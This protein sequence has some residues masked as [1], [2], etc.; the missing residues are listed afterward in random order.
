MLRFQSPQL[1]PA[2]RIERHLRRSREERW[3]SNDG[4]CARLLAERLGLYVGDGVHAVP[5]A[6]ATL[7]LMV[8]IEAVAGARRGRGRILVPS[9]T[10]VAT[11]DAIR[12]AG[13]EPLFCDVGSDHWHMT[14]T[15][16]DAALASPDADIVAVLACSTFGTPP[17]AKLTSAWEASCRRAGVP[18]IVDSAAG[19]GSENAEGQRLGRQGDVEIFSFHATK[20]FA[21][22][23]GG[24]VLTTDPQLA[25]RLRSLITFGLGPDRSIRLAGGLNAKLSE[26]HAATALAVLD[27]FEEEVLA[28]RR[29]RAAQLRERLDAAV[30]FQAGAEHSAWQFVPILVE[31][32]D[33]RDAVIASAAERDIELRTYHAPLHVDGAFVG[34]PRSASLDVTE[35]LGL[36]SVSLPMANDLTVD[37]ADRIADAVLAA[38]T[39]SARAR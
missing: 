23:E 18:L 11:V 36:R 19:F 9:F 6:N 2:D 14:A 39:R 35:D 34:A 26:L 12:W 3:F 20:P 8:A 1:P 17:P 7:G 37:D 5:V 27:G 33:T 4:P 31:D 10:Y 30:D 32:A 38:C 13:F 21:I 15:A 29:A 16:L 24:A 22:G 25:D 28:P